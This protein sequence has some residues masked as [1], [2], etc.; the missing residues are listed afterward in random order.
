MCH[1]EKSL[2]MAEINLQRSK[3]HTS[4]GVQLSSHSPALLC[5]SSA[6][7]EAASCPQKGAQGSQWD[8]IWWYSGINTKNLTHSMQPLP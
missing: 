4:T 7:Q 1:P 5:V 2:K 6:G 3:G 8:S